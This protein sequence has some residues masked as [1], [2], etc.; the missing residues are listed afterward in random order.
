V[1]GVWVTREADGNGKHLDVQ[2]DADQIASD[3]RGIYCVAQL[4]AGRSV[5]F[6]G[7]V[8]QLA[9]GDQTDGDRILMS[10]SFPVPK[11]SSGEQVVMP[12][13]PM[14]DQGVPNDKLPF[15]P[16]LYECQFRVTGKSVIESV[17]FRVKP[18]TC[19]RARLATGQSCLLPDGFPCPMYGTDDSTGSCTCN[20]GAWSC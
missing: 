13:L 9:G 19:P 8:H 6:E 10:M 14:D 2:K 20:G 4:S 11:D 16:G 18:A 1:G 12:F 17:Q 7:T 5:E 15:A 3:A